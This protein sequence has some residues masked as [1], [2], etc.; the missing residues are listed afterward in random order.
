M[1]GVI[2]NLK[3]PFT[4]KLVFPVTK[5]RAIFNDDGTRLDNYLKELQKKIDDL[6]AQVNSK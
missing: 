4:G 6:Q 5:T 3:N 2:R 1:A